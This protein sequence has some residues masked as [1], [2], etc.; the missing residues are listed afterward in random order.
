MGLDMYLSGKNSDG[1]TTEV[2]YWRKANAIHRWF[3]NNVQ[4]GIDEC[5]ET[6]VTRN[7]LFTLL[8]ICQK[9]QNE[10][11]MVPG[12]VKNGSRSIG[13]GYWED[14]LYDGEIVNN[15]E[16]CHQLLPVQSGF[17]FGNTDYDEHYMNHIQ[18]TI[19]QIEKVLELEF[20]E[21]VYSSS[22]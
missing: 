4:D 13:G 3:V 5:Q 11:T 16:V 20:K 2:A 17:F 12:L 21:F 7:Q 18:E 15:P 9:I 19:E 22:W 8:Q 10:V 1:S 14:I 6:I